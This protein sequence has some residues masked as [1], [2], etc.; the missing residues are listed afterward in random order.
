M[1]DPD[2]AEAISRLRR[3]MAEQGQPLDGY[4]DEQIIAGVCHVSRA[5]GEVMRKIGPAAATAVRM[6]KAGWTEPGS[7]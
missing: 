7:N 5:I 6:Y 4:T 1:T 2:R 3:V